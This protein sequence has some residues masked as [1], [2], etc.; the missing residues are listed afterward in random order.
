MFV[1]LWTQVALTRLPH[2][3]VR[4]EL[5]NALLSMLN[6]LGLLLLFADAQKFE[7]CEEAEG[8]VTA[9]SEL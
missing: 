8:N 6:V 3:Q 1:P 7:H 4:P 2:W 9:R 5:I